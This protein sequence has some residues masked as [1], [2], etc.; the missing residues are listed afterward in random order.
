MA[1]RTQFPALNEGDGTSQNPSPA[2][3][4]AKLL[5]YEVLA[6]RNKRMGLNYKPVSVANGVWGNGM[7]RDLVVVKQYL[8]IRDKFGKIN[9]HTMG[10]PA[11]TALWKYAKG[12][13]GGRV[14][15]LVVEEINRRKAK[16]AAVALRNA[17]LKAQK[18]VRGLI[19]QSGFAM[20]SKGHLYGYKQARPHPT[21]PE[22][23]ILLPQYYYRWDCSSSCEGWFMDGGL[24][25]PLR[26]DGRYDGYGH[27]GSLWAAGV[28]VAKPRPADLAFYGD[29]YKL[30]YWR[31]QHV[32]M[33]VDSSRVV[34]FGS[35]PPRIASIYYRSDFRGFV[36]VIG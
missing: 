6:E 21:S 28:R 19:V 31:P 13:L 10:L 5:M 16:A 23:A 4:A 17:A 8:R 33:V 24:P 22:N 36:D 14:N 11:W 35:N 29:D 18:D 30:G 15:A 3:L 1:T 25:N 34:T 7:T 32:A 20:A 9:P 26:S 2:V 12:Q 27:T